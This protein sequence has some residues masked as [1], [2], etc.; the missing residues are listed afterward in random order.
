[1]TPRVEMVY[2]EDDE[3]VIVTVEYQ[4]KQVA[5]KVMRKGKDKTHRLLN[6][7]IKKLHGMHNQDV[8]Y[9]Q[10]ED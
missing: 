4:T 3:D 2:N 10:R 1:M 8:N 5:G 6:Q 7:A 9:I